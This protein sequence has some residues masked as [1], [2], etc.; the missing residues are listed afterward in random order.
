M[1]PKTRSSTVRKAAAQASP[2]RRPRRKKVTVRSPISVTLFECPRCKLRT[3]NPFRR[4]THTCLIGW[5]P[6]Q[7]RAAG[8]RTAAQ[9]QASRSNL[10]KARRSR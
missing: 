9:R 1:P 2:K 6:A 4:W 7:K 10:A 5:T 8:Q 3:N